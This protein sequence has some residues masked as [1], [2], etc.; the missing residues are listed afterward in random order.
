MIRRRDR[1]IEEATRSWPDD[2]ARSAGLIVRGKFDGESQARERRLRL[3]SRM[4]F[5]I[6]LGVIMVG[7]F[8]PNPVRDFAVPSSVL[9]Q[10]GQTVW[11][12]VYTEE[13]AKRGEAVFSEICATCH[14][15]DLL[16]IESAPG[17]TGDDFRANW[18]ALPVG[19]LFERMRLS[20]PEDNP[21]SMTRQESADVLAFILFRS[22]FPAGETEL[23]SKTELLMPIQFLATRP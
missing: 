19:D 17:L 8:T 23:A 11:A 18:D 13:Q 16:G 7:L 4:K 5:G 6:V 2:A 3:V 20:M 15:V 22:D 12:G 14:G 10:Q 21:G 9:A 1:S